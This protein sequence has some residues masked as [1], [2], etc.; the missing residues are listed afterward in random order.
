MQGLRFSL[1]R[2]PSGRPSR[3][4]GQPLRSGRVRVDHPNAPLA[5][6]TIVR[7]IQQ[8]ITGGIWKLRGRAEVETAQ[9]LLKADEIDFNDDTKMAEARGNV[10]V[11]HYEGGEELW[12]DRAEYDTRNETGKYYNI[13]GVSPARV[14][15]SPRRPHLDQ[16]LCLSGPVGGANQEPFHP[17]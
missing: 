5:N 13:R 2:C 14:R 6:E 7:G 9:V 1:P 4:K 8:E 16:S 12:A 10:Y 17:S 15:S 11:L 3:L